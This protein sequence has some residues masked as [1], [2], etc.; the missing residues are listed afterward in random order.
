S[1]HRA[2]RLGYQLY[3]GRYTGATPGT[4]EPVGKLLRD[5]AL[6]VRE[7]E[8]ERDK[9]VDSFQADTVHDALDDLLSQFPDPRLGELIARWDMI[10]T[11][12]DILVT[13]YSMLN[14]MLMREAEEPLFEQ[15]R[16]WL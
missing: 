6:Q 16:E 12:P 1:I 11:P 4:G 3:F 10:Q 7:M 14:V 15:T 5:V 13:N 2:H 8:A 9:L